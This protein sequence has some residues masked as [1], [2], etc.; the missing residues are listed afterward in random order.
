MTTRTHRVGLGGRD[1][2]TVEHPPMTAE[3]R[4]RSIEDEIDALRYR[5]VEAMVNAYPIGSTVYYRHG[6]HVRQVMV[7]GHSSGG[8]GE[9]RLRVEGVTGA[10]YWIGAG[11]VAK[12]VSS[13]HLVRGGR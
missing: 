4:Y 2:F 12:N 6:G 3:D 10:L 9:R 7:V 13:S 1:R 5:A 11:Q 8:W